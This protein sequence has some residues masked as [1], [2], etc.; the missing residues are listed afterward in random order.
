MNEN[1][2]GEKKV[3]IV[4]C[5]NFHDPDDGNAPIKVSLCIVSRGYGCPEQ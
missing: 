3:I 2:K 1:K 5:C 4:G